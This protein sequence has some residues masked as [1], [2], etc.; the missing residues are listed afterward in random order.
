MR[1]NLKKTARKTE[2]P[3]ARAERKVSPPPPLLPVILQW[4]KV[5]VAVIWGV[6]CSTLTR[7]PPKNYIRI[8]PSLVVVSRDLLCCCFSRRGLARISSFAYMCCC[9][10]AV[11]VHMCVAVVLLFVST[12]VLLHLY[13]YSLSLIYLHTRAHTHTH[14]Y[15]HTPTT[16]THTC[17]RQWEITCSATCAHVQREVGGWGLDPKK[18]TER[19]WG[20]GSSTI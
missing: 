10:V 13:I 3:T 20:M 12:Y 18:C 11:C 17:C 5:C 15:T 1:R 16:Y 4:F 6:C 7:A 19:D 8:L 14:I 9:L 2:S